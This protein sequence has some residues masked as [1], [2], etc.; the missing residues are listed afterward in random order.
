MNASAMPVK[1][2]TRR[3][4][5]EADKKAL[6]SHSF[7]CR[8]FAAF[9]DAFQNCLAA[10]TKRTL[11]KKSACVDSLELE[12]S[13]QQLIHATPIWRGKSGSRGMR[14]GPR[15]RTNRRRTRSSR[16]T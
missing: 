6:T 3:G 9:S 14:L 16:S 11:L 10:K 5:T 13:G 8:R 2:L 4:A 12:A 7:Q 15:F 1:N